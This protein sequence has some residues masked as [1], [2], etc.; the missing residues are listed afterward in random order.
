MDKEQFPLMHMVREMKFKR[1][2][3]RVPFGLLTIIHLDNEEVEPFANEMMAYYYSNTVLQTE[4]MYYENSRA[5]IDSGRADEVVNELKLFGFQMKAPPG[6][7][8]WKIAN[9]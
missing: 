8:E 3:D 7:R 1:D 4:S 5:L 6:W 2:R 9:G